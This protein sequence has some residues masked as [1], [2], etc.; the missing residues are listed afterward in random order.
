MIIDMHRHLWSIF[1]RYSS[2]SEIANRSPHGMGSGAKRGQDPESRGAEIRQEMRDA[3]VDRSIIMLGDYGIRL[4]EP[5]LSIDVENRLATDLSRKDPGHFVAFFGVDPRRPNAAELF[6]KAIA[7]GAKGLKLHPCAGF[8]PNDRIVFPLYEIAGAAGV[9]VAIHSGPMAAPLIS[10]YAD[11]IY[12]DEPAAEFQDTTF[13]IL[14]AGMRCWFPVALEVAR[15]SPNIYLELA[16]WQRDYVEQEEL[17]VARIAEMGKAIGFERVLFG[18]DCPGSSSVLSLSGWIEV[19]RNLPSLAKRY[20]HTIND[21]AVRRVLG[22]N[23]AELLGID[24]GASTTNGA[25]A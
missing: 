8:Y 4:G 11:P 24:G 17:F 19:F 1:E 6:E 12:V 9:P 21:D 16:L 18:S 5:D 3:G 25:L 22:D 15:W 14:H 20:G 23:A 10:H 2:V 7:E 13:I